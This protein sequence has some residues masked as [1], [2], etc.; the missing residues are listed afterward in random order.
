MR[1][2]LLEGLKSRLP[3][4]VVNGDLGRRIAGNLHVSVPGADGE[5]LL[6]LLDRA[7]IACSSGS[8]CSSGALDPSHVLVALGL[9]P[10]LASAGIRLSL[11][12]TSTDEDVD[13]VLTAFPEAATKARR[14]A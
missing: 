11:G 7:G 6:L 3:D 13:A 4:L 2:R 8:A 5:T 14:V 12:W 10:E 1:T 9:S